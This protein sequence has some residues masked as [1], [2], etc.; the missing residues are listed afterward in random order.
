MKV[1]SAALF[2]LA[3]ATSVHAQDSTAVSPDTAGYLTQ[4]ADSARWRTGRA[5]VR[6]DRVV[7][8]TSTKAAASTIPEMLAGRVPGLQVRPGSGAVGSGSRLRLRGASGMLLSSDPLVVVDGVRVV[9]DAN[10]LAVRRPVGG[11]P[12]RLDDFVPDDVERVEVLTGPAAIARYGPDGVNGVVEVWTRRGT[13][14]PPRVRA[15]AEAGVRNDATTYPANFGRVGRTR[16]GA[17]ITDCSL[18]LQSNGFCTASGDSILSF[19][20]L[21]AASPFR[22]G[23]RRRAGASVNGGIEALSY[24]A[25]GVAER[26]LGVLGH[27]G[28]E[29]LEGR[30]SFALRPLA[31]LELTGSALHLR[32]TLELPSNVRSGSL[33]AGL[34]GEAQDD[35][36]RRGYA[37]L[38][39]AQR[40]TL[41]TT[42][43]VKRTLAVAALRWSPLRWASVGASYGID[44]VGVDELVHDHYEELGSGFPR[45]STEGE[46]SWIGRTG[47]AFAEALYGPSPSLRLA[48]VLGV[49]RFTERLYSR[50]FTGT[51]GGA[52]AERTLGVRRRTEAVYLRQGLAWRDRLFATASA[53]RDHPKY[54]GRLDSHAL[55]AAWELGRE[56]FFPRPGWMDGMRL[57][58]AYAEAEQWYQPGLDLVIEFETSFQPCGFTGCRPPEKPEP[59][60]HRELEGG[61]DAQLLAGR[62]ELSL[63]GYDRRTNNAMYR[64]F[65]IAGVQRVNDGARVSNRGVETKV[66]VGAAP[67]SRFFWE[68]LG[69]GAVNRNR[70]EEFPGQET[71]ITTGFFDQ[72]HVV[73]RP[74]GSYFVRPIAGFE[75]RNRDGIIGLAGCSSEPA[76]ACEVQVSEEREYAGSPDPTRMIAL[77]GRARVRS[78]EVSALFDHHGGVSR[79]NY[80]EAF[81]CGFFEICQSSVDPSTPLAEQARSVAYVVGHL[82]VEDAS[83][84]RLRE[85]AVTV[86]IPAR[87]ARR[88]GGRGMELTVAG[89]NLLTWT[90]YRGLDPET[91][92]AGQDP[93]AFGDEFTQ[94]LPRTIT[95]RLDV[96][97]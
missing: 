19:N 87:W 43:D 88:F 31:G 83:F 39:Q 11:I 80:T 60:R 62:M 14:G 25:G 30:G 21:E 40:D 10:N 76:P 28:R 48:T 63:T 49:E 81:R 44:D 77:Q 94:P 4:G 29:R 20:P 73:G 97:F 6:R 1:F 13:G 51:R 35:P 45:P 72:R 23:G 2:S 53:R 78:V 37:E 52:Y 9:R 47:G 67:E 36:V 86:A 5:G 18:R 46:I 24:S 3:L 68:V 84:T 17:R 79:A 8:R 65:R 26:D 91:S 56:S 50:A 69:T 95:T 41:G 58:A 27:D 71:F 92:Y 70:L 75:D 54:M 34:S 57:R 33:Q 55:S 22:T 90:G 32:N 64:G 93:F 59:Q 15:F 7:P 89:R 38:T 61:L 82:P 74:L 85:A 96:T 66:R 12:S 16:G 42:Q